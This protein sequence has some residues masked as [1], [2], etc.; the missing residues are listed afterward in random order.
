MREEEG[1]VDVDAA[2]LAR[3]GTASIE[4]PVPGSEDE[5]VGDPERG[6]GPEQGDGQLPVL[7]ERGDEQAEGPDHIEGDDGGEHDAEDAGKVLEA[8]EM[9]P[10]DG[11]GENGDHGEEEPVGTDG[12]GFG[13]SETQAAD[14][15]EGQ[16][17]GPAWFGGAWANGRA[18]RHRSK[19]LQVTEDFGGRPVLGADE[20]ATDDAVAIDDVGFG[21]AGSVKGVV[22]LIGGVVDNGHI[23][24][25]VIDEVLTVVGGRSVKGDSDNDEVGD[26]LLELLHRGPLRGA[27]GTPAGPEI[28]DDDFALVLILAEADGLGAVVDDDGG[29]V[30]A[31]LGGMAGAVAA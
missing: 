25:V 3:G 27:V 11:D 1:A 17:R 10:G 9:R 5:N 18:S 23:V 31:D 14:G 29:G 6:S 16:E 2:Q 21:R 7:G 13:E 22:G 20:F 8:A 24:E 28:K 12:E 30:F 15:E 19:V 4:T 26:A